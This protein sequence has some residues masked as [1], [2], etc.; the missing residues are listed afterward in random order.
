MKYNLPD[1]FEKETIDFNYFKT[2]ANG[3][4]NIYLKEK[5]GKYYPSNEK[6]FEH[7]SGGGWKFVPDNG[8]IKIVSNN[9]EFFSNLMYQYG[10][11]LT[12]FSSNEFA[13]YIIDFCVLNAYKYSNMLLTEMQEYGMIDN[14][15]KNSE[16]TTN[17]EGSEKDNVVYNGSEFLNKSGTETHTNIK[18][19]SE[20][21]S[22]GLTNELFKNATNNSSSLT[23]ANK[24]QNSGSD[25]T[26]YNNVKDELKIEYGN[27]SDVKGFSNRFDDHTKSFENRKNVV[28]EHTHGNIGV[29]TSAQMLEAERELADF[30]TFKTMFI[31]LVKEVSI[32]I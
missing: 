25:N 6:D 3:Q 9:I 24:N 23:L 1:D 10:Y 15:N 26:T 32:M 29:T 8:N 21:L 31:D 20:S 2:I 19:G 14:Y 27:R 4:L 28:M 16:I 5:D 13:N 12:S 11:R 18:S 7:L 30:S 22:H 17:F